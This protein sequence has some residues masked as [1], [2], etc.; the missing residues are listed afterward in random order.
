MPIYKVQAPDGKILQIEGPEDATDD[1]LQDAAMQQYNSP[2]SDL[3]KE[4]K[5]FGEQATDFAFKGDPNHKFDVSQIPKSAAVGAGIGGT[6]GAFAGGPPGAALGAVGG[7]VLGA[8]GGLAEEAIRTLGGSEALALAGGLAT[9]GVASLGKSATQS[10]AQLIHP[11]SAAY[12]NRAS[13]AVLGVGRDA[14]GTGMSKAEELVRKRV[15]GERPPTDFSATEAF[16]RTQSILKQQLPKD[17]KIPDGKKVSDFYRD[18][19][20]SKMD[21]LRTTGK[22]FQTSESFKSLLTELDEAKALKEV[23]EADVK[24]IKQL[25]ANQLDKRAG[26]VG[27][28]NQSLLNLAQNGGKFNNKTGEAE[29]LISDKAQELLAKNFDS[30]FA[31]TG[32][33]SLYSGLKSVERMEIIAKVTDDIPM[34][35]MG[36]MNP[37]QLEEVASNIKATPEGKAKFAEGVGQYF[38]SLEQGRTAAK[39]GLIMMNEFERLAPTL[40]KTGLMTSQQ[41]NETQKILKSIPK[42]ISAARWNEIANN[43]IT[44]SLIAGESGRDY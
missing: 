19:M 25:A 11:A 16:D 24:T 21:E 42:E 34:L 30:Y 41:L 43:A 26:V 44:S 6:I 36:K 37:R 8:L 17:L 5:S 9:G 14:Q 20:Y 33:G 29:K 35:I 1:E 40:K 2:P 3:G 13:R 38:S 10:A 22:P 15:L 7:G 23:T 18:Q 28:S 27:R 39:T 31:E 32:H 12:L 4:D